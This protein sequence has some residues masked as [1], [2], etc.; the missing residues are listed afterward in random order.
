MYR[1]ANRKKDNNAFKPTSAEDRV[2]EHPGVE[3]TV[4]SC[5][6]FF[7]FRTSVLILRQDLRE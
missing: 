3:E 4:S 1:E 6:D 5:E 2:A 7:V